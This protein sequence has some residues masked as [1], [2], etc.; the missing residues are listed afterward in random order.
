MAKGISA[1]MNLRALAG[2]ALCTAVAAGFLCQAPDVRADAGG[3]DVLKLQLEVDALSA[4]SDLHLTPS[5]LSD[6]QGLAS[7]TAA[8]MPSAPMNVSDARASALQDLKAALIGGN[9]DK[10]GDAED[11]ASSLED[12]VGDSDEPDIDQTDAAKGKVS[13]AVKL[14]TAKQ[15]AGYIGEN[16]DDVPDP[17]EILV[18]AV[19]QCH[20]L[21][22]D[23]YASL[24][25][26]TTDQLG[27]LAGGLTPT[28]TPAIIG[29][30]AR[31][32]D[33]AHKLSADEYKT[34]LPTLRDE[35]RKLGGGI[36]PVNVIRHWAES[37]MADL[38]S[39]PQLPQALTDLGVTP[40]P[41]EDKPGE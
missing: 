19:N 23:D 24:K 4:L 33:G 26:D 16:S 2:A 8:T 11:K 40:K 22:S 30:S 5:Q 27:E 13:Q 28:K 15:L 34:Q 41:V 31:F 18:D 35:A 10:I 32:L 29:K 12:E 37:D 25:E 7:D 21:S 20:D 6:L 38:L 39:N 17:G 36:D 9:D 1:R 14:L 3:T